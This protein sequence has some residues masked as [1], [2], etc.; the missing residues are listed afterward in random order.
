[1]RNASPGVQP[2]S[3]TFHFV[4]DGIEVAL[5]RAREA[6]DGRHVRIQGGANVIQQYLNAGLV[7]EFTV[8]VA[9]VIIG[10]GLRLFDDLDRRRFT[11]DISEAVNSRTV[12]HLNCK[13]SATRKG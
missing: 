12:T 11:V 13:V 9:P 1:M 2:G 10:A 5:Q 8:H 3:T 7:D 4:N 6:A